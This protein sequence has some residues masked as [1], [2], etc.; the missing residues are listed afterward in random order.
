[1]AIVYAVKVFL[2]TYKVSQVSV[3]NA[4]SLTCFSGSLCPGIPSGV[5]WSGRFSLLV[6]PSFGD[7]SFAG[8]D[9]PPP[10]ANTPAESPYEPLGPWPLLFSVVLFPQLCNLFAFSRTDGSTEYSSA[11]RQAVRH[12]SF[13]LLG[14]EMDPEGCWI[15]APYW[16]EIFLDT[17]S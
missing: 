7:C 1:M 10:S 6:R 4:T 13:R 9:Q 17:C 15:P 8:F 11:F 3:C 12:M 16:S 14:I 2:V 5:F